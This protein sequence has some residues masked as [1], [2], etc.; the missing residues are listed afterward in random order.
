MKSA[1][2]LALERSGGKLNEVSDTLKEKLNEIEVKYK[3]KAA[4]AELAAQQRTV[5]AQAQGDLEKIAEI[6]EDLVTELASLRDRAEREKNA[7][8]ASENG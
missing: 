6:K 3:A 1:F 7:A 2:E 5:K 4:E 8:R